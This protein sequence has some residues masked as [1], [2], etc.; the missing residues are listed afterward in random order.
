[1]EH[2]PFIT[3]SRHLRQL[4]GT[5]GLVLRPSGPIVTQFD[6]AQDLI[7]Q[8]LPG[9]KTIS[10]PRPHVSLLGFRSEATDAILETVGNWAARQ[11]PLSLT[12]GRLDGFPPPFQVVILAI[13]GTLALSQALKSARSFAERASL[14]YFDEV[15]ED[16]WV[17]HA[18]VAYCDLL[19]H[20]Q[21]RQVMEL[22]SNIGTS[23]VSC[24]VDHAELRTF[25]G[26]PERL[27][28]HFPLGG[29]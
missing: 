16:Q 9:E 26:G 6:E 10:F 24:S 4:A 21:W 11:P 2:D 13:E 7:R 20:H 28:G 8:C 1:M 5:S 12:A 23:K 15:A 14:R 3:D 17:F 22:V 25:D 27:V 29:S 18:S 19:P